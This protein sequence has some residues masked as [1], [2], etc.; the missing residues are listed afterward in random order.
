MPI[1][2]TALR[3]CPD[4]LSIRIK[5]KKSQRF[6]AGVLEFYHHHDSKGG[7][8]K[9]QCTA[10]AHTENIDWSANQSQKN[11]QVDAVGGTDLGFGH[12]GHPMFKA[13][14]GRD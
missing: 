5:S 8:E 4:A 10:A 7:H 9:S 6:L 13:L 1:F 2:N 12:F 11:I 3:G 14:E